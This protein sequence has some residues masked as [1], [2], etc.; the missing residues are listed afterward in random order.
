[1]LPSKIQ[2]VINKEE[3][4]EYFSVKYENIQ[5]TVHANISENCEDV[6]SSEVA[7]FRTEE[8]KDVL[9]TCPNDSTCGKDGV[10]YKDLK[11]K[12]HKIAD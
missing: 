6:N 8:I 5:S 3:T 11:A 10:Y 12:W 7:L 9:D 4:E 1:M 2:P